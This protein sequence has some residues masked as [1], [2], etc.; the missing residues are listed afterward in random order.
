M[1]RAI[2][3]GA[4]DRSLALAEEPRVGVKVK[5][6][7]TVIIRVVARVRVIYYCC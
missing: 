3:S 2:S 5:V 7:V 6:T 1:A 4:A